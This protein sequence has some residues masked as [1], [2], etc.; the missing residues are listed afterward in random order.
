MEEAAG[1]RFYLAL[2]EFAAQDVPGVE[3]KAGSWL[4]VHL[5][6]S[7]S[8]FFFYSEPC[9]PC[10]L[11]LPSTWAEREESIGCK[12]QISLNPGLP[13]SIPLCSLWAPCGAGGALADPRLDQGGI[14]PLYPV[15][16]LCRAA[17][18]AGVTRRCLC[19]TFPSHGPTRMGLDVIGLRYILHSAAFWGHNTPLPTGSTA[20][21][22]PPFGAAL[23]TLC[24]PAAFSASRSCCGAG[25]GRGPLGAPMGA[26]QDRAGH[27]DQLGGPGSCSSAS[28]NLHHGAFVCSH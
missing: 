13:S 12:P 21:P 8:Y 18:R 2:A 26:P 10:G 28:P 5:C 16:H 19:F 23:G 20:L 15:L 1:L 9:L 24:L 22:V 7:L 4:G 11:L 14:F 25:S 27:G 17:L 6:C 3:A